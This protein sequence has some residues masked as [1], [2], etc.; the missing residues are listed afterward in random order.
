MAQI[1]IAFNRPLPPEVC[2]D[3]EGRWYPGSAVLLMRLKNSVS[4]VQHVYRYIVKQ[5]LV[6]CP[7]Q[8]GEAELHKD[9]PFATA[10]PV[11][12]I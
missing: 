7:V 3:E 9:R 5:T 11:D 2:G 8:G 4:L 1:L 6:R 12:R 10:N